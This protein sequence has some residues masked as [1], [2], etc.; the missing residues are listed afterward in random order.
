MPL[1]L[2][3]EPLHPTEFGRRCAALIRI[4]LRSLQRFPA[5]HHLRL[6]RRFRRHIQ[7]EFISSEFNGNRFGRA[8][9]H[10]RFRQ[11]FKHRLFQVE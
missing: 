4:R 7:K 10:N 8:Q 6:D 2:S 1:K 3:L 9:S 5:H 11:Q